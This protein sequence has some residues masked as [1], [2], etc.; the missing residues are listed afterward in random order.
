MHLTEVRFL[1]R[2]WLFSADVELPPI[3]VDDSTKPMLLNLIAHE[4]CSDDGH[5]A[6]VTSYI[7]LL[8]SLIDHLED[9]KSLR[10]AGV[11]ENS[12]GS[13][14]E[15]AKLFNEIGT[16]LVP[17]ILAYSEAKHKIQ[18]HYENST[19]TRLSELK[20]EYTHISWAFLAIVGAVMALFL[21][22]V[23]TYFTVWSPKGECDELCM[24]LKMN[25]H[26]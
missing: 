15:V 24:F 18:E 20:H 6:W 11:L 21:S 23:Q 26:L 9:V 22:G 16:D 17:N 8:D 14:K 12:L 4:M 2:W 19:N 5:E 25:H 3:I 1:K 7:R 10:K 13:D